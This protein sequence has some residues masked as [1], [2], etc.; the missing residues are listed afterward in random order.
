[1]TK[2]FAPTIILNKS[3]NYKVLVIFQNF[4]LN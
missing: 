1:M 4:Y 2:N 3:Y